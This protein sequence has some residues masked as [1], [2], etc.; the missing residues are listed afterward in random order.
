MDSVTRYLYDTDLFRVIDHVGNLD[1]FPRELD[2][3][4][5]KAARYIEISQWHCNIWIILIIGYFKMLLKVIVLD[6]HI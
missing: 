2:T 4:E 5:S 1:D 6:Q 3:S